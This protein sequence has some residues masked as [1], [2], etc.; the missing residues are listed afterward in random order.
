MHLG[1]HL[2]LTAPQCLQL[3]D[4]KL[5]ILRTVPGHHRDGVLGFDNGQIV[6]AND[7]HQTTFGPNKVAVCFM[8]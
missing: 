5:H 6:D 7:R 1:V 2:M 3:I 4:D 8:G